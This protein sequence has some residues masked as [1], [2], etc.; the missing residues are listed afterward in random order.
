[1]QLNQ[2]FQRETAWSKTTE[3]EE[4]TLYEASQHLAPCLQQ[5]VT[6]YNLQES[7]ESLTAVLNDIVAEPVCE[8]LSR[9]WWDSDA[10]TLS[11]EDVA[12]VLKVR[13]AAAHN[14]VL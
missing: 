13:V 14:R 11:L 10:R 4:P 2:R 12:E 5:R 1:M 8:Y 3:K 7:L 9:Q 6:R